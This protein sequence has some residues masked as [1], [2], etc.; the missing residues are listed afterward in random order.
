MADCTY[1]RTV[2]GARAK[3]VSV[4]P[5]S[6]HGPM[7]QWRELIFMMVFVGRLSSI[8]AI[9]GRFVWGATARFCKKVMAGELGVQSRFLKQNKYLNL[10]QIW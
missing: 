8:D 6:S 9:D 2:P 5:P 10:Y 3:L 1:G 7:Y 4:S